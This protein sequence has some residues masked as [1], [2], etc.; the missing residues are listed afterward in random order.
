[1]GIERTQRQKTDSSSGVSESISAILLV[2]IVVIAVGSIALLVFA[3]PVPTKT[4]ALHFMTGVSS[5]GTTLYLYHNGGDTLNAGE[6]S[7]LLD[8]VPASY[9]ISGG[10]SQWSVGKNLIIPITAV[11]DKVTVVYGD[12]QTGGVSGNT[13]RF[14]LDEASANIVNSGN[15]LPDQL[16]YLD[17][18]AVKN[19]DCADQI[20]DDIILSRYVVGTKRKSMT[21]YKFDQSD[22]VVLQGGW[23]NLTVG[24]TP[25]TVVMGG[26]TC[27]ASGLTTYEMAVGDTINTTIYTTP[28]DF[29]LYGNAPALWEMNGGGLGVIRLYLKR[30]GVTTAITSGRLCHTYVEEYSSYFSTLTIQTNNQNKAVNFMVNDTIEMT[31]ASSTVI[32][33]KNLAP[34]DNGMYLISYPGTAGAPFYNIGWPDGGVFYNGVKQT[35]LGIPP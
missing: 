9:T 29:G 16:P 34:L 35:G 22:G 12:S 33:L 21:L 26:S 1:M 10:G 4:P 19:W 28:S 27:A 17:C 2:S 32:Q 8:G 7:V 6:F 30:G 18:S 3:Q 25:A 24:K 20:P 11:P 5:S 14:M 13:G 23:L 31:G 15:V